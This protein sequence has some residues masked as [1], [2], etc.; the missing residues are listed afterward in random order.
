VIKVEPRG[1]Y[2]GVKVHLDP[3]DCQHLIALADAGKT[4]NFAVLKGAGPIIQ[5]PFGLAYKMGKS[6]KDL[7]AKEPGLLQDRTP[8]QVAAILA[9][10]SE[11]AA[12]QLE[13]V[14]K[15]KAW[16]TV[17]PDKLKQALLKHAAPK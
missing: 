2:G 6:I 13:A 16:Q 4:D 14:K 12:L 10:E 8:E 3:E 9:K 5:I 15:G 17:D 1:K 11:K 7:L